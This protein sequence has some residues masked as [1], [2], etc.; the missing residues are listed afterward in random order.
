QQGAD[1]L[2]FVDIVD[3]NERRQTMAAM[4]EQGAAQVIMP[5]TI[6]GGITSVAD[7]QSNRARMN[8]SF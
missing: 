2:V 4:V 6:G 3:T 1:E 5:L 8:L 7:M